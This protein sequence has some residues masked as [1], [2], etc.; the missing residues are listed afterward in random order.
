MPY[1]NY[2]SIKENS[3]LVW[4]KKRKEKGR[5]VDYYKVII[6]GTG[7][8]FIPFSLQ[9]YGR[10]IS[11]SLW[12]PHGGSVLL[13]KVRMCPLISES[14]LTYGSNEGGRGHVPSQP[15]DP[16]SLWPS[17]EISLHG[18]AWDNWQVSW[19]NGGVTVLTWRTQK[20]QAQRGGGG[21]HICTGP[22]CGT[23]ETLWV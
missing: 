16:D 20:G 11:C 2:T 17:R 21:V 23:Y 6:K 19:A 18:Q 13:E 5:R 22:L 15:S 10:A 7:V 1:V 9:M 8:Y 4:G 3:T 14:V 12:P